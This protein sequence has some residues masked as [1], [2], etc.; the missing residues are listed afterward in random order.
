MRCGTCTPRCPP[1]NLYLRFFGLSRSA[2]EG[3][4]RR[5]CREP[6]PDHGALAADLASLRDILLR[7]SQLADDPP[8]VAELELSP[9]VA[10]PDGAL[11]VDGRVRIQAAEPAD[12]YLRQLR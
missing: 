7:V 4:A 6:A 3:E 11:A 10:R 1:E 9:V 5:V 12:A 8:Q 2:A